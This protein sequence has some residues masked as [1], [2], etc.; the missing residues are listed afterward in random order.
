[1]NQATEL[2]GEPGAGLGRGTCSDTAWSR[3]EGVPDAL[4]HRGGDTATWIQLVTL[5]RV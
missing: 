5:W 2:C 4:H 3:G 1:M